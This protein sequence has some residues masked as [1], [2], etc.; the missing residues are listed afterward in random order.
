MSKF[1]KQVDTSTES[2]A[3]NKVTPEAPEAEEP[4]V[5][6]VLKPGQTLS[7]SGNIISESV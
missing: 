1:K 6:V 3:T 4:T 5:A 7:L 2:A